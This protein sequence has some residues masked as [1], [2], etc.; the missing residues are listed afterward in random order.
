LKPGCITPPGFFFWNIAIRIEVG[1]Q[2]LLR[3]EQ[4]RDGAEASVSS[5]AL[6]GTFS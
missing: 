4:A 6:A 1:E 3:D 5:N 2:R